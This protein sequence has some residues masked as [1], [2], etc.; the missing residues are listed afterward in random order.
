VGSTQGSKEGQE[1]I[2]RCRV[3]GKVNGLGPWRSL[4]RVG[5]PAP[6]TCCTRGLKMPVGLAGSSFCELRPVES[7]GHSA[8]PLPKQLLRSL[9]LRSISPL[10]LCGSADSGEITDLG[11]PQHSWALPRAD[12]CSREPITHHDSAK[13]VPQQLVAAAASGSGPAG[14]RATG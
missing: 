6:T 12:G 8:V 9:Q 2:A 7:R 11:A 10:R 5:I 1:G 4:P 3:A 14:N 13:R